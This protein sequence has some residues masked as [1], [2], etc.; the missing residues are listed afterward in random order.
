MKKI[1]LIGG[2]SWQSTLDYYRIIN[3]AVME[4]VAGH[5][6]R[7]VIDSLDF[8][9]VEAFIKEKNF[10]GIYQMLINSARILENAGAE[11]LLI[12][13][14]TMHMAAA[15]VQASIN[16]PLVHVVDATILKI[17]EKKL[18][19]VIL[20]G[21]QFTMEQNFFKDR[22]VQQG[23]EVF[24]PELKDREFIHSIIFSELF[25]RIINPATKRRVLGIIDSLIKQGAQGVILGC[26]E[27]PLLL[28]QNDCSIPVFDTT[29]IHSKAAV[30][31]ALLQ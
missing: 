6:A 30:E 23:I 13:A 15:E 12:G 1:G 28:S 31:L 14:N 24:V 26:T 3:E 17:R 27:L 4:R 20:L 18:S 19:S 29:E 9:E 7:I 10:P 16:I 11:L 22:L 2:T 21:T 25:K 5:S 8:G